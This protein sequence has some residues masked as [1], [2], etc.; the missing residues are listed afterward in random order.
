VSVGPKGAGQRSVP[1]WL[2]QAQKHVAGES[3]LGR[4]VLP[5]ELGATG[6]YLLSHLSGGVTCGCGWFRLMWRYKV[7]VGARFAWI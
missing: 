2:F 6:L 4:N 5:E 7:A 1:V 3:C